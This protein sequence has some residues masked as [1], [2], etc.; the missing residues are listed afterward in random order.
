M[1]NGGGLGLAAICSGGGQGDALLID[2]W[3]AA[4]RKLAV[5]AVLALAAAA[6]A[7][8]CSCRPVDLGDLPAADGAMIG[9]VLERTVSGEIATYLF[10]V[11]QVYKGDVDSRAEVVTAA[12]GA[13]CTRRGC[14]RAP[15][16]A[17]RPRGSEWRPASARR[18][19]RRTSS[20]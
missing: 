11:E 13:A 2:V 3:T 14:R 5:L 12:N 4:M 7:Y 6:E 18:S 1:P 20:H 17:A 16:P 15:R 10:R 9:T 19:T 8:A